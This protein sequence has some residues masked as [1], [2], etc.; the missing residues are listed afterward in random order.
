[1]D[2]DRI[3]VCVDDVELSGVSA[4]PSARPRAMVVALHGGSVTSS[5]Y[6]QHVSGAPSYLEL[7]AELGLTMVALDRP[8]YGVSAEIGAERTSF[9]EQLSLLRRAI[10]DLWSR[11]GSDSAGV[12]LTGNS[13]GGMLALCLAAEAAH[14]PLIGVSAHSAGYAW[15]PGFAAALQARMSGE[16]ATHVDPRGRSKVVFGP[17]WTWP[18]ESVDAVLAHSAP[19]AVPELRDALEW[20]QRLER[21]AGSI[22]VPVRVTIA[23]YDDRWSSEPSALG[24][25]QDLF[26]DSEHV[27]IRRQRFAGHQLSANYVSRAFY[28]KEFAFVEECSL[29]A[30][31][32]AFTPDPHR[33]VS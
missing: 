24:A 1:M 19:A 28:L 29:A 26:T 31:T 8:G 33:P 3:S 21:I 27:E 15:I 32:S 20:S 14:F 30:A 7:G 17:D 9:D 12:V 22:T 13:I 2:T 23:E 10:D 16:G 18:E 4:T 25:L 6:E 5:I 11:L